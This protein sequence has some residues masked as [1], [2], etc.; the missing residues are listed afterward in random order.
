[1]AGLTNPSGWPAAWSARAIT[2]AHSG[3]EAL[4]PTADRR[5]PSLKASAMPLAWSALA[6]TSGTPRPLSAK[7]GLRG[8]GQLGHGHGLAMAVD[9]PAEQRRDAVGH[10]I[11]V[12]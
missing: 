5:L 1:M 2:P 3:V 10:L 11:G 8:L 4:V 12:R 9:P 7:A 6:A